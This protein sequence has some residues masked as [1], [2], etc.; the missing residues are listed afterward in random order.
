MKGSPQGLQAALQLEATI[1][2]SDEPDSL[3]YKKELFSFPIPDAGIEVE[4]IFK[5]GAT[6]SYD[7]GISSTFSGSATVDFGLEAGM[8]DSAQVTADI[9]NPGSSS[10]TGWSGGS[11][12]PLFDIKKESASVK[13]AA[14]SQPKLAFGIELIEVGNFEV[15]LAVK[16]P[17][18]SVT[19]TAAYDEGGVCGAG[20]LKTGIKLDSEVDIEVDLEI[21]AEFGDGQDTANSTWSQTLY[22]YSIPLRSLCF[23][24]DIPGLNSSS[25]VTASVLSL[26]ASTSQ[27]AGFTAGTPSAVTSSAGGSMTGVTGTPS[28][29][30]TPDALPVFTGLPPSMSGAV[31]S[32]AFTTTPGTQSG[33]ST[34]I[35]PASNVPTALSG[36]TSLTRDLSAVTVTPLHSVTV[37]WSGSSTSAISDT[38]PNLG[39]PNGKAKAVVE[40]PH[41]SSMLPSSSDVFSLSGLVGGGNVLDVLNPTTTSPSSILTSFASTSSITGAVGHG[42]IKAAV[43]HSHT[44]S[45]PP[46]PSDTATIDAKPATTSPSMTS[47]SSSS[48]EPPASEDANGRK[49]AVVHPKITATATPKQ[50]STPPSK[51]EATPPPDP[52]PQIK[53]PV[54]KNIEDLPPKPEVIPP[55]PVVEKPKPVVP[56]STPKRIAEATSTTPASGGGGCRMVKRFGK[57]ML[58]C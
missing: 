9:Q 28:G 27:S 40:H 33:Q 14:F 26:S 16:L 17:E 3:Q 10:A 57:R 37:S 12:T 35:G 20:S 21:D 23:P 41:T 2:S 25:S 51:P 1:T 38:M 44:S 34:E 6:L 8:P 55:P 48:S 4:G 49:A 18:V 43:V 11:L 30:T 5:L 13:L 47:H 36:E 54:E 53:S 46:A 50:S 32:G 22:S 45:I 31:A 19:L 7:V 52:P 39:L 42:D 24:L 29:S 15:A 58:V 56:T